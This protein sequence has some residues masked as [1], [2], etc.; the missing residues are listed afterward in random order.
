MT[1]RLN[2]STSGYTDLDAPATAGNNTLRLPGNNGSDGQVFGTDGA[3]NGAWVDRG[4]LVLN[5]AKAFNW[6][7]Q[8]N[9]T[10]IDFT[11]IPS[12]VK[13]I[14][15][16]LNGVSTNG[17]NDYF[18]RVGAGSIA[19][20]GYTGY[21]SF[22]NFNSPTSSSRTFFSTGFNI[23]AGYSASVN[24]GVLQLVLLTGN[25]WMITGQIGSTDYPWSY[26]GS[27]ALLGA[28]DRLQLATNG[29]E[30]FDAGTINA[31]YEG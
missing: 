22:H 15:V 31:L 1:L 25:T 17:V 6:N 11:S 10:S 29:T 8:T 27:I 24:T 7:G 23:Y 21:T 20:T 3:G 5:T 30:T 26:F 4:R 16:M 12:W 9:N 2:G 19:I 18:L 13:R 28:L 14:T